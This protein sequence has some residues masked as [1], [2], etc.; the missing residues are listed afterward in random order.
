MART[1]RRMSADDWARV[2]SQKAKATFN[3][4]R[5]TAPF[6]R[7]RSLACKP[8]LPVR[9]ASSVDSEGFVPLSV[10]VEEMVQPQARL[11]SVPSSR[12]LTSLLFHFHASRKGPLNYDAPRYV[13]TKRLPGACFLRERTRAAE[14]T[15]P[16]STV[17]LVGKPLWRNVPSKNFLTTPRFELDTFGFLALRLGQSGN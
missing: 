3:S 11:A 9:T 14:L 12:Q 2:N 1:K 6:A 10:S 7:A 4:E 5:I 8:H 13:N 17:F 15:N 16:R